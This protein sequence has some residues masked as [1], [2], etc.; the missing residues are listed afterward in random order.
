MQ[1]YKWKCTLGSQAIVSS[2][3]RRRVVRVAAFNGTGALVGR[4]HSHQTRRQLLYHFATGFRF[5]PLVLEL[6]SR[7]A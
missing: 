6:D 1:K 7:A 3:S 5:S 2:G 4:E